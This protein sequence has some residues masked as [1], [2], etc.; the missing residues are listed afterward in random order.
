MASERDLEISQ[1]FLRDQGKCGSKS[2]SG[3]LCTISANH[4]GRNHKAQIFGGMEDGKII[5]EWPW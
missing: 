3:K 2:A 4:Q 5:E 1:K